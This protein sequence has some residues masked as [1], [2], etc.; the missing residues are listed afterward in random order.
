MLEVESTKR[1]KAVQAHNNKWIIGLTKRKN[2]VQR[3]MG[4]ELL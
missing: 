1:I 3:M 4:A 2:P